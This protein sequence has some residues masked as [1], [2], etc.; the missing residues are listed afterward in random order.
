M[1]FA[2]LDEGLQLGCGQLEI[3]P[4]VKAYNK[5]KPTNYNAIDSPSSRVP[6]CWMQTS[7]P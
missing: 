2:L 6:T 5:N 1:K 3:F 7:N 4:N